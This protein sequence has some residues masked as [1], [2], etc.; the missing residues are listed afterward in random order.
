[1]AAAALGVDSQGAVDWRLAPTLVGTPGPVRSWSASPAVALDGDATPDGAP[2]FGV[3]LLSR[4]PVLRW[5]LLALGSGRAAL[6]LRVP[7]PR[8]G[9]LRVSWF[10]DEPRVALAALLDGVTVV[11]THLSFAPPTSWRQLGLLRRWAAALPGPVVLAG[12][13]NL[14]GPVA[15][16]R[17][18]GRL[19]ARTPTFPGTD[20]R[21]QL[22]HVIALGTSSLRGTAASARQ[23]DVGDH[24]AL[25]VD[26]ERGDP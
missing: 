19:L 17:S 9:R 12:D 2:R 10:P 25:S 13:L 7:D 26:V 1:V 14:P 24:R 3:A 5:E 4:L 11:G 20:P 15:A 6:P 22:D 21:L 16:R 8:T 18:R 23:L